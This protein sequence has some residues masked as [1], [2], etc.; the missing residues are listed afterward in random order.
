MFALGNSP[1]RFTYKLSDFGKSQCVQT[2]QDSVRTT[3][4]GMST[5][6]VRL[7]LQLPL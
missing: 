3:D 6:M 1:R 5:F 7:N 4:Y 2:E